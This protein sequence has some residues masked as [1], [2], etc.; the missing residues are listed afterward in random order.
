MPGSP[1]RVF[2]QI[3]CRWVLIIASPSG[4][5][6]SLSGPPPFLSHNISKLGRKFWLRFT[7]SVT[8]AQVPNSVTTLVSGLR[9]SHEQ[10]RQSPCFPELSVGG[11][12]ETQNSIW[13]VLSVLVS[14]MEKPGVTASEGWG[15]VGGVGDVCVQCL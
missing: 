14:I 6:S 9:C 11:Q 1:A 2:P 15:V 12:H 3:A 7:G 8:C 4:A 13:G 10:A 5:D